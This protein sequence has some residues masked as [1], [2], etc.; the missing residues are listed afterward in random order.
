MV[1]RVPEESP[2]LYLLICKHADVGGGL[3]TEGIFPIC[4]NGAVEESQVFTFR[5]MKLDL[6]TS[7]RGSPRRAAAG[8]PAARSY[9]FPQRPAQG[10]EATLLRF[11][12]HFSS[13]RDR[14]S[15]REASSF[16]SPCEAG[17]GL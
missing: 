17:G 8:P 12:L 16:S 5:V 10:D 3:L 15:S 2:F 7:Q 14:D 4:Q 1:P 6:G 9:S 13:S 11:Q